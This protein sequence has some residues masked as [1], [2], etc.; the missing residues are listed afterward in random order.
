MIK[1]ELEEFHRNISN[2]E[3]LADIKRVATKLKQNYVTTR[4]QNEHGKYH[5]HTL[6]I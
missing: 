3:L 5:S 4:Q 2:E 6:S 1:F